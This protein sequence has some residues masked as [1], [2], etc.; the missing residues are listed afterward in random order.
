M[1]LTG[2]LNKLSF[3]V[4]LLATQELQATEQNYRFLGGNWKQQNKNL[5][6]TINIHTSN[7]ILR[8]KTPKFNGDSVEVS[9][10]EKIMGF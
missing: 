5:Y 4:L 7:R 1:E 6:L 2:K 3:F 9:E 8:K 10:C